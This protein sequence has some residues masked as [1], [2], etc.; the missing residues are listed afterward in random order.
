MPR[1]AAVQM[2]AIPVD[3][4]ASLRAI[5]SRAEDAA[6]DGAELVVFPELLVPGYPRYIPDPFPSTP[7]GEGLWQDIQ[8]YFKS[9]VAASQVI[10]GPF[11]DALGEIARDAGVDLVVGVSER[12]PHRRACLW[13]TAV[14]LGRDGAYLGRRRKTVA[15]M[16]ERLY[17]QRGVREDVCVFETAAGCVGV[18]ICFENHHPLFRRALG[19]LGAEIL[20]ALWTAPAPRSVAAR[21]GHLESHRELGVAH[22]LDTGTFV[23]IASQVTP[24]E[25]AGG[26]LG[27]RW[28]HSGGSYIIDPLG[29]TIASVP[30]WEEGIAVADLDL[31]LID[32]G[33]LIWNPFGDDLREDLFGAG[34]DEDALVDLSLA[35]PSENG[36]VAEAEVELADRPGAA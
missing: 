14:V 26:E 11:T 3:V 32:A 12:H 9:Y 24:R 25:P 35:E 27:S 34:L 36:A 13:N 30:D 22:A 6:S 2:T 7:E 5:R 23:V 31:S 10:P 20:C 8:R 29:E 16:H 33:R 19:A 21:G 17:F 15:V 4:E 28:A 18:A 1:V